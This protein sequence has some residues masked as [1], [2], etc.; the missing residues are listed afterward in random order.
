MLKG[1]ALR[2]AGLRR[3]R[4]SLALAASHLPGDVAVRALAVMAGQPSAV[5]PD[6][7]EAI[8]WSRARIEASSGDDS[9]S[10]QQP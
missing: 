3:I 5:H 4:R 2:R 7:A 6:V 8:D 9:E 10:P 1:S